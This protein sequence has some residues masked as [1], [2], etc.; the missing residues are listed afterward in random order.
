MGEFISV[1]FDIP[2]HEVEDATTETTKGK[3]E[4]VEIVS[5]A[6]S[7][8]IPIILTHMTIMLLGD[9]PHLIPMT[10]TADM[11]HMSDV[12]LHCPPETIM[13]IPGMPQTITGDHVHL[14]I[15]IMIT[16]WREGEWNKTWKSIQKC[17]VLAAKLTLFLYHPLPLVC[18]WCYIV[19][20]E[21]QFQHGFNSLPLKLRWRQVLI[22]QSHP[23]FVQFV[24]IFNSIL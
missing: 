19:N 5:V 24:F 16:I 7:L 21:S 14:E 17:K 22:C 2:E 13:T 8:V 4:M 10:A 18:D 12:F 3:W 15:H 20:A 1:L 23:C 9:H 11:I 6:A